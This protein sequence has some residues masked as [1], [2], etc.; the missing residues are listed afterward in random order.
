M[1]VSVFPLPDRVGFDNLM[2]VR[3]AG[4]AQIDRSEAVDFDLGALSNASSAV[5]ALLIA[6]FRYAH[7]RGKVV[8]FL[9]VPVAIMNIIDVSELGDVLPVSGSESDAGTE[10]LQAPGAAPPGAEEPA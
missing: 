1:I 4:E 2:A 7:A 3:S 6:W 10:R 9:Q 5:V 8:R